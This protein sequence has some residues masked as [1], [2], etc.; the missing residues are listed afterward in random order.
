MIA[1][2]VWLVVLAFIVM[3]TAFLFHTNVTAGWFVVFILSALMSSIVFTLN[4]NT[5]IQLDPIPFFGFAILT[6]VAFIVVVARL[7]T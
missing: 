7:A 5:P 3:G 4:A 1:N 6:I 2:S